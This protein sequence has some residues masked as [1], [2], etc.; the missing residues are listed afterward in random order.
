[1]CLCPVIPSVVLFYWLRQSQRFS[2]SL[3]VHVSEFLPQVKEVKYLRGISG[4]ND[5]LPRCW[6][7]T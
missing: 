4:V 1:M 7:I 2:D 5:G 3:R 6:N